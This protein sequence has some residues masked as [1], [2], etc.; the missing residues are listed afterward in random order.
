MGCD[1][2]RLMGGLFGMEFLSRS[3]CADSRVGG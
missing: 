1:F 3:G 2:L